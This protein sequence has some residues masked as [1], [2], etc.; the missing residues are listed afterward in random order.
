MIILY[1][2]FEIKTYNLQTIPFYY[3]K[4]QNKTTTLEDIMKVKLIYFK[5][6]NLNI[7]EKITIQMLNKNESIKYSLKKYSVP[8]GILT[9]LLRNK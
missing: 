4:L 9:I 6:L 8:Y 7:V 1:S 3:V 2:F 5:L